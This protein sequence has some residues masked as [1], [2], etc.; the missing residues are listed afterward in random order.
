MNKFFVITFPEE[1][2]GSIEYHH[3]DCPTQKIIYTDE[4]FF[5]VHRIAKILLERVCG[6]HV[7][8]IINKEGRVITVEDIP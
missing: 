7:T 2:G 1:G 4:T 3:P 6:V 5:I 8:D